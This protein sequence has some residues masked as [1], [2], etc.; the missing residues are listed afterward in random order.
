[1]HVVVAV[2]VAVEIAMAAVVAIVMVS[3]EIHPAMVAEGIPTVH[4]MPA[5]IQKDVRSRKARVKAKAMHAI[6]KKELLLA[7]PATAIVVVQVAATAA[8]RKAKATK[9]ETPTA[10]QIAV[11]HAVK[12]MTATATA[13][14][15]A[16]TAAFVAALAGIDLK[17]AL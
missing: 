11:R 14:E 7:I 4:A 12:R 2:V 16:T 15:A 10:T 1:M 13:V 9:A 8:I 5:R 17:P 6:Q 3:P